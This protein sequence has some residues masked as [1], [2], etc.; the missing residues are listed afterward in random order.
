MYFNGPCASLN[1]QIHISR[2]LQR[3]VK[4][5]SSRS[6]GRQSTER[7]RRDTDNSQRTS[8]IQDVHIPSWWYEKRARNRVPCPGSRRT[9]GLH[10]NF[11][12]LL[13]D[14]L[15]A[16][17][18]PAHDF[19]L[20]TVRNTDVDRQLPLPIFGFWIGHFNRRFTVFVVND[21][22]FRNLQHVLVFF[23]NDFS[24]GSHLSFEF[25]SGIVDR[26]PYFKSRD[27]IFLNAH[28]RDL[29]DH[30]IEG[31]VLE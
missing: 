12:A 19:C 29:S 20:S 16:L 9:P 11:F 14:D 2:D 8:R 5:A 21:C 30:A 24:V 3:T 17:L 4:F 7:Q 1:L 10:E 22:S 27:V 26:N 31:L 13:Q 18:Q 6:E 23:E 28:G 15:I 25:A